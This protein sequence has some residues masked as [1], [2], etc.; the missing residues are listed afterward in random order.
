MDAG[1]WRRPLI[2]SVCEL[3]S[4]AEK[5]LLVH[6]CVF[7]VGIAMK[8]RLNIFFLGPGGGPCCCMQGMIHEDGNGGKCFEVAHGMASPVRHYK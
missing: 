5:C 7:S 4:D 2:L 1:V 3:R 8:V 6:P